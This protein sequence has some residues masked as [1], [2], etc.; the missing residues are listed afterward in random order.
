MNTDRV[1]APTLTRATHVAGHSPAQR[2]LDNFN[3]QG[4]DSGNETLR[5]TAP[6]STASDWTS[7]IGADRA[8]I[9]AHKKAATGIE[10]ILI[11][12]PLIN[13]DLQHG[14]VEANIRIHVRGFQVEVLSEHQLRR[15]RLE[16]SELSC[17]E[18]FVAYD[19][20]IVNPRGIWR[21]VGRRH[22]GSGIRG[23]P[24]NSVGVDHVGRSPAGRERWRYYVVEI[25][26][27]AHW[28]PTRRTL[29]RSRSRI[30]GGRFLDLSIVL[31]N[32]SRFD[33]I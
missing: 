30:S 18:A 11:R 25:F 14:A 16:D 26:A 12:L 17:F 21:S 27:P 20:R 9:S 33:L 7:S 13:A 32:R 28:L 29:Q 10:D 3:R 15:Y 6:R 31:S 8:V 2:A 4:H 23:L 5:V 19:S 22:W 24:K 1:D